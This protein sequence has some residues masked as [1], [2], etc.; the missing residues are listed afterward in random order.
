MK[1]ALVTAYVL[2]SATLL[3]P[4]VLAET[5]A[6]IRSKAALY[7]QQGE[8][9]RAFKSY[10]KLAKAGD[11][12]SQE[13][14]AK[15]Y[16]AGEGRSVN[17]TDAYAWAV[18]AAE[19]GKESMV[20]FSESLLPRTKNPA[21]AEKKAARLIKNYGRKTQQRKAEQRA[22]RDPSRCIGSLLAC[23]KR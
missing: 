13:R 19:G 9:K 17:L 14:V 10:L 11:Q 18:V 8:F 4:T 23:K 12:P 20:E 16:E 15:M 1:F 22:N 6:E 5:A 7:D 3:S 2:L 21:K